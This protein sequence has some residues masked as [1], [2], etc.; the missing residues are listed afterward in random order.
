[1]SHWGEAH[2]GSDVFLCALEGEYLSDLQLD[3]VQET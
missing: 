2:G 1:M 3:M